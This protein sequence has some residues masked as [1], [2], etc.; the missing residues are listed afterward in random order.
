M[1]G[2]VVLDVTGL[3]RAVWVA[4]GAGRLEAG[5]HLLDIDKALRRDRWELRM[6]PSTRKHATIGGFIAGGAAGCL[7][8][9]PMTGCTPNYPLESQ[10]TPGCGGCFAAWLR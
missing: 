1:E 7:R 9:P 4:G 2:G 6:H 10:E 3:D 5:A 8:P